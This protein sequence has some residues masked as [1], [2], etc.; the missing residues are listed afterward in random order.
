MR[1]RAMNRCCFWPTAQLGFVAGRWAADRGGAGL[2]H[3]ANL[4]PFRP[5]VLGSGGGRHGGHVQ[6]G[7]WGKS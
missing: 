3:Y 4:A 7:E 1:M 2:P 6:R 5:P